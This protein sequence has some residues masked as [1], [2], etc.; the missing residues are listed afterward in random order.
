MT[1]LTAFWRNE[2]PE[3]PPMRRPRRCASPTAYPLRPIDRFRTFQIAG[4]VF[5]RTHEL[6]V[7]VCAALSRHRQ[8]LGPSPQRRPGW[9]RTP[10]ILA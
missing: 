8:R 10:G 5:A 9:L 1:A 4:G 2:K 3:P 6:C 7:R